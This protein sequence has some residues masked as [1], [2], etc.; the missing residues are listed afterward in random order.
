MIE[1]SDLGNE[2]NF[3]TPGSA[4]ALLRPSLS[5]PGDARRVAIIGGGIS[6]LAAAHRIRELDPAAEVTLFEASGRVGGVLETVHRKGWL[7]ERSADMF[8]TREPWA[9]DLC[10]RIGIAEELIETDAR[11]RRAFVVRRGRLIPVPEG[12]TL[13]S[14][15]KIWP[16]VATPL[17]SPL[18]KLRLAAEYFV[19]ARRENSDESMESFVVRR[20]GREAFERLIQPLI[21]G[22]YT[23]DPAKLSMAA[24]LPQF[25][26]L[27]RRYG[28]LIRGMRVQGSEFRVQ[29]TGDRGQ[30]TGSGARY[31]QFVA[32]RKGMQR[33]VEAMVARLPE[34][35]V[36]LNSSVSRMERVNECWQVT[37]GE[38]AT[39]ERFDEIILAAPG[40]VS[41]RLLETVDQRLA[42]LIARI[43]YAG[44]SVAVLGVCRDQVEHP[45][46]GFGFV[47]PAI[48]KRKIIACSM[49]SVKFP[50]RAP[51]GKVLLRVFVGGA[52]QPE[53][54]NLP[55]C[56]I[57]QLVVA[58][59]RELIG[60]S[61]E[62]EFFDVARWPGMMPQYHVGH[63]D[64][65]RQIEER[66]AAIPH[67]ALAG[68]AY[69]GVGIPFCVRS[70]ELAAERIMQSSPR[71]A[72]SA[73]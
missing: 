25:V 30:G 63:L 4:A 59:L 8:T 24:T 67:F 33:L 2:N 26:E 3:R 20:F 15:A 65:I 11:Y 46:D 60:L 69:R 68:N 5:T 38:L 53:L 37:A 61:G 42:E 62:P 41:S 40:A 72:R 56:E 21:G 54:G 1:S 44:C 48:E 28:S 43:P 18:G 34:Q 12:F 51:E 23:A 50:G 14:P 31:G 7:T 55:D 6:G 49:A 17:L 13:M 71:E 9:L 70:G 57:R 36:R 39:V 10:R 32:P 47:V 22:I 66:S 29:E 16:I 58:E 45:L 52:L 19:S 35:C 73:E 64:L 27:E